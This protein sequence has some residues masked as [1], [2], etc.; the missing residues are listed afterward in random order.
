MKCATEKD[1]ARET[2]RRHQLNACVCLE[3][4]DFEKR[5]SEKRNSWGKRQSGKQLLREVVLWS[6]VEGC[7]EWRQQQQQRVCG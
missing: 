1:R 5:N 2:R 4:E 3:R 6:S 7:E